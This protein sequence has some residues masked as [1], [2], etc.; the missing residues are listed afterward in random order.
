MEE[1]KQ[2]ND[3]P[4]IKAN[5]LQPNEKM[6]KKTNITQNNACR[7]N[8]SVTH[9]S[10]THFLLAIF[11]IFIF[12]IFYLISIADLVIQFINPN[13]LNNLIVDD[14]LCIL[15]GIFLIFK[16]EK[17]F[18]IMGCFISIGFIANPIV[19]FIYF[20]NKNKRPIYILYFYI[21]YF[22]I[23]YISLIIFV[24]FSSFIRKKKEKPKK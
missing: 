7:K 1:E 10:I 18:G 6:T 20:F 9:K 21:S 13:G 2:K 11:M 3:I 4:L 17:S 15:S 16:C 8:G 14:I 19:F 12:I 23:K 5:T 24:L 22:S